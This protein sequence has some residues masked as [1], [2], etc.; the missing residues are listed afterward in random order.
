MK[1]LKSRLKRQFARSPSVAKA[2]NLSR[3]GS[4]TV[5]EDCALLRLPMLVH[6]NLA[7]FLDARQI[8]A[9]SSTCRTMN[10][11]LVSLLRWRVLGSLVD[12]WYHTVFAFGLSYSHTWSIAQRSRGYR[13]TFS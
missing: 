11:I 4:N 8:S 10:A 2:V 9:L 7:L 12:P 6:A 5:V 3:T 13:S 1:A